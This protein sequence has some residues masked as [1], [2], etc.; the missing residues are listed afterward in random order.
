MHEDALIPI[1]KVVGTHGIRGELKVHSWAESAASFPQ[2]RRLSLRREG[3]PLVAFKIASARPHK[4]HVLLAL[5]GIASLDAAQEWIGCE[6]C[7][8]KASLPEPEKGSYYW[9]QIIGLKVL[10]A[11]ERCLGKVEAILPT[12][13]NDVYVVRE[14]EKEILIPAIESVVTD[15][16]LKGGILRVDLPEGLED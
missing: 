3:K 4:R 8:D 10:A 13:S 14:G 5:E 2:G 9:H 6:L 16:D 7:I 15:I 11:D 1:G 12:G